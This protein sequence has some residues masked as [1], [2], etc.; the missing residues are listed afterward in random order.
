MNLALLCR[1]DSPSFSSKI[2]G[3][4]S[5]TIVPPC[6]DPNSEHVPI[7][8]IIE[9]FSKTYIILF[10]CYCTYLCICSPEALVCM[11]FWMK[12]PLIA[13]YIWM[14]GSQ[15][16]QLFWRKIRNCGFLGGSVSLEGWTLKFQ[17]LTSGP[18]SPSL[19]LSD[20]NKLLATYCSSAMPVCL[21]SHSER[22]VTDN[23]HCKQEL[24]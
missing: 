16:V 24:N 7:K 21:L 22:M 18:F 12:K 17:I 10:L 19:P 14:L 1:P 23:L 13:S 4:W 20:N 11:V 9:S 6:P 5:Y 8:I 2:Q 3:L 15:L